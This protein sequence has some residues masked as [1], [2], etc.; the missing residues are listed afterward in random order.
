MW[1]CLCYVQ[2]HCAIL[3]VHQSYVITTT[4]TTTTTDT[5]TAATAACLL[6]SL[7]FSLKFDIGNIAY[8]K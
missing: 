5:A 7:N 4:T 8:K 3:N 6:Y 2:Y 1:I